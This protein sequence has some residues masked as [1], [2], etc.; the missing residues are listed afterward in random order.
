MERYKEI[1]KVESNKET[2]VVFRQ[3]K[4]QMKIEK[5]IQRL[6]SD[7]SISN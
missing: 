2:Q 5:E 6:K 7:S 3:R 4:T 1:R